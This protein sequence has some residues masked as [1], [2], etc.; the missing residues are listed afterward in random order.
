MQDLYK[1]E[2]F[3]DKAPNKLA[4]WPGHR[5][6]G[7]ARVTAGA[8]PQIQVSESGSVYP[9]APLPANSMTLPAAAS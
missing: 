8:Y 1:V 9:L 7:A 2:K 6:A 4:E 3:I 5:A